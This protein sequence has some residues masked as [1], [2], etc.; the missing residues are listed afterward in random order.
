MAKY[1]VLIIVLASLI[2]V[3][4]KVTFLGY[5]PELILPDY[6]Y[7]VTISLSGNTDKSK[8]VLRSFLP[9]ED[10]RQ[11][12]SDEQFRSKDFNMQ[13]ETRG[14][15][16]EVAWDSFNPEGVFRVE[17][18]FTAE[19][20]PVKWQIQKDL[21]IEKSENE[22][23]QIYLQETDMIPFNHPSISKLFEEEIGSEKQYVLP[24]L[25][26]A[27]DYVSK[28]KTLPFK[29]STS[30]LTALALQKASCN[31]KSRLMVALLRK[32][33]IPARLIGGLVMNSGKKKTSHQ[34]VEA[35]I[36]GVWVS[37][38]STN[39]HFAK[40]PENYLKLYIGDHILFKHTAEIG[41]QWQFSIQPFLAQSKDLFR[42]SG[43]KLNVLN[44]FELFERSGVSLGILK[45]LLML[46]VGALIATFFRNVIGTQTY[47]T[48]LPALIAASAM[49]TGI[50][51]GL[52]GFTSVILFIAIIR[53]FFEKL[54][55]MHTPKLSAMFSIVIIVVIGISLLSVQFTQIN[56][57]KASLFPIAILT[58]TAERL[59]ITIEEKGN[60]KA[61]LILLQTLFVTAVC[62]AFMSNLFLQTSFLAFPELVFVIIGLNVWL[63]RWV[64]LRV[65]E[66]W[67]F[68]DLVFVENSK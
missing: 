15:N 31:G 44:L 42:L 38:D 16:R 1:T 2:L 43:N 20:K 27:F 28:I 24:V 46:P 14:L 10:F 56:L 21:K 67:R 68:K 5:S 39:G 4:Y 18:Q 49:E 29:G 7:N 48:F 57:S 36:G 52:L 65:F 17:Y 19:A 26:L 53:I 33:G 50:W 25:K 63:G 60:L 45:L 58:L 22:E 47:G 9:T 6:N 32:A 13:I 23:L 59:S 55:L 8:V 64:G 12:I 37:F 11:T 66:I 40:I 35:Y 62:F 61:F 34:W 3:G 54:D 30:A 41:F 51:W